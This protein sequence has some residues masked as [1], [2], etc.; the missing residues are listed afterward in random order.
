LHRRISSLLTEQVARRRLL[1]TLLLLAAARAAAAPMA[2]AWA[3]AAL[4]VFVP[5]LGLLFLTAFL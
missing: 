4:A 2:Q 1:N 5:Q 3:A